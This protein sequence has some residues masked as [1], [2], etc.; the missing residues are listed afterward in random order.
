[1]AASVSSETNAGARYGEALASREHKLR[2]KL[3]YFFMN[4]CDKFYAKRRFPY[5][6][7]IQ[8]LKI[9]FVTVQVSVLVKIIR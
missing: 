3:K 2:G 6:L 9:I 1:M 8:L 5:K 7:V 4:P